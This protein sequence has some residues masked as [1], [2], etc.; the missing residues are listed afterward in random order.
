MPLFITGAGTARRRIRKQDGHTITA[1]RPLFPSRESSASV[2]VLVLPDRYTGYVT[3]SRLHY[4]YR[5]IDLYIINGA[6]CRRRKRE[7]GDAQTRHDD[8]EKI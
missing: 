8:R 2:F 5:F 3:R 7:D 6:M 4:G 1:R